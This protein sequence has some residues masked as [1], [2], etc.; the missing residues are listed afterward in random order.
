[1]ASRFTRIDYCC[2]LQAVGVACWPFNLWARYR[3]SQLSNY[4][5]KT[6]IPKLSREYISIISMKGFANCEEPEGVPLAG[7]VSSEI[8]AIDTTGD[9]G[10]EVSDVHVQMT[11]H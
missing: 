4:C 5:V 2:H 8:I 9:I 7:S 10:A 1:V 3:P 11:I 6:D